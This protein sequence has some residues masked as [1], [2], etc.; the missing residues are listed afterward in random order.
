[1]CSA[2]GPALGRFF[3]PDED[4]TPWSH[5]VIVFSHAFW[6]SRLG[7]DRSAIGRTVTVNGSPFIVIGVA[8]HDFRGI[9]TGLPVDAWV[10][11]M[12]QPQLRP[13]SNLTDASWLWLFGRLRDGAAAA[14][15]AAGAHGAQPRPARRRL[16]TSRR[17]APFSSVRVSSLTG[18]PNGEG[19]AMLGFMSLLLGAASLVLLIA[20]VNVAA[21]LSARS[22]ERSREMAVRAALGAGRASDSLR[23][24]LTEI[25]VLFL[26]GAFGGLILTHFAT[27]GARAASPPRQ[28]ATLLDLSPD[29]RVLAF[30]LCICLLTGLVFGL[31][32][33]LRPLAR[34]SRRACDRIRRAADRGDSS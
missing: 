10:P 3:A 30:A 9:Y 15:R 14:G 23:Q 22:L 31:A 32:P 8:P 28:R 12:M 1:M 11:L 24:L 20:G 26:L 2:Y 18:L 27:Y 19:G 7:A 21:M 5:P 13:R 16:A 34:T 4:R 6:K 29:F 25:L 33:A 17:R